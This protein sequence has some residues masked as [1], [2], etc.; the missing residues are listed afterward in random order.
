MDD[1]GRADWYFDFISPYSY[2]QCQR[3]DGVPAAIRPRPVL[4]AGLLQHW[5]HK[6][7][8]EMA[9]KR[10]FT[11]RQVVWLAQRDGVPLRFPPTHPFNPIKALR[12]AIALGS[13]LETIRAIYRYI[14]ALGNE[15]GTDEGF[16]GL[17]A[18]LGVH[19]GEARIAEP[20]V[21]EQ[22]RRN[23]EDAI[24]AGVF[25]VPTLALDGQLFWGYDA[26]AMAIDYLRD[27]A[28]FLSPEIHRVDAL[29]IG[30]ARK[31]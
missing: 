1:A 2:L 7:P 3:L 17:C 26:T 15:A 12:L 31:L 28:A 9:S 6:G 25:G 5:G 8:A 20:A 11:Y 29:P 16:A 14:W 13:D 30:T 22:L 10:T 18:A 19:D 4:F 23:G 21:K 24:A 27:P